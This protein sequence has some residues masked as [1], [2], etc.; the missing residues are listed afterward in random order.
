MFL[1]S[2][3]Q[4]YRVVSFVLAIL[5]ILGFLYYMY[6][7]LGSA[8][9]TVLVIEQYISTQIMQ[10][11]DIGLFLMGGFGSLFFLPIPIDILFFTAL[12]ND[13]NPFRAM[14][15]VLAGSILGTYVNYMLGW[16]LS[17]YMRYFVSV[18]KLYD[19]KRWVNKYGPWAIFVFCLTPL[20]ASLLTFAVGITRYNMTRLFTF[21]ILGNLVK[22]SVFI[23]LFY[24]F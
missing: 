7:L 11:T 16:Q 6:R 10:V 18:K 1:T 2:R 5:A 3:R 14:I 21:F 13:V 15:M 19:A 12:A 9:P 17:K 8:Y 4:K 24:L 23:G 22:F 20:P